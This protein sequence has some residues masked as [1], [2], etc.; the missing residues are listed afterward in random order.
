MQ[1]LNPTTIGVLIGITTYYLFTFIKKDSKYAL[2]AV[3]LKKV[4]CP[5]CNTPQPFFRAPKNKNQALF[6][7]Y[8]CSNCKTEM[9]KFGT[10]IKTEADS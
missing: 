10:E 2:F 1:Y 3:N 5:K 4:K 9:D 6:G 7:G 8:T